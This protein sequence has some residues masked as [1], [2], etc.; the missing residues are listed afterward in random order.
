MN[1]TI[2]M[3]KGIAVSLLVSSVTGCGGSG[4][5]SDTPAIDN[6][7]PIAIVSTVPENNAGNVDRNQL[8]SATFD[9]NLLLSSIS[10]TN[11]QLLLGNIPVEGEVDSSDS[12]VASLAPSEQLNLLTAYTAHATTGIT[13]L[14]GNSLA[15]DVDWSF[16]T[17]DGVWR[18]ESTVDILG[19]TNPTTIY[20]KEGNTFVFWGRGDDIFFKQHSK[21]NNQ[22]SDPIAI[23]D[24][25]E[26]G[27]VE[28]K[29]FATILDDG[30]PLI[31]WKQST[32]GFN[33]IWYSRFDNEEDSSWSSPELISSSTF[34]DEVRIASNKAGAVIVVWNERDQLLPAPVNN[35]SHVF[36]SHYDAANDQWNTT[37]AP[38]DNVI[39]DAVRARIAID[40]L[41][42]AMVV[43]LQGDSGG[44]AIPRPGVAASRYDVNTGTWSV[45]ELIDAASLGFTS[46]FSPA[47]AVDDENNVLVAWS[48]Q[49]FV[50]AG[51]PP[52]SRIWVNRYVLGQG[53]QEAK[54]ITGSTYGNRPKIAAQPDGDAIVVWH[55]DDVAEDDNE[56]EDEH[57]IWVSHFNSN[58]ETWS[59]AEQLDSVDHYATRPQLVVDGS[60]NAMT[61]WTQVPFS[62]VLPLPPSVWVSRYDH[63]SS[64][65]SESLIINTDDEGGFTSSPQL[66]VDS[67]G[68]IVIVWEQAFPILDAIQT[69]RFD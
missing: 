53:W 26:D 50:L 11:F 13:D 66:N 58:A 60:G 8:V 33:Q 44:A 51:Q 55:K 4:G 47:I 46:T 52:S 57:G 27:D 15:S 68:N 40:S 10:N 9:A 7:N 32:E 5:G 37:E 43:W 45:S 69:R 22:W 30:N 35:E 20:D 63:L 59:T 28:S 21:I 48:A 16:T 42:N 12:K 18:K 54:S 29:V 14:Q 25:E 23:T 2:N 65:W 19:G 41:G 17:R 61:I 64:S 56:S 31:I 1:Y 38:L 49:G 34:S 36:S 62:L 67:K 3:F 39:T 6:L 24:S